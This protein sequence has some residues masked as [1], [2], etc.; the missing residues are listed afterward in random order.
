[1]ASFEDYVNEPYGLRAHAEFAAEHG[2]PMS[3]PEWGL[4]RNSDNPEYIQGMHD[5]IM[6]HDVVYQTITDYC[7]HGV[8][9]CGRNPRSA[10]RYRA[11]CGGGTAPPPTPK[12][13]AAPLP[14]D[15]DSTPPAPSPAPPAP[16]PAP[17]PAPEATPPAAP[18]PA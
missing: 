13:P 17:P 9:S 2:K 6:S 7:P 14:P 15:R 10:E 12:S 16:S 1:G 3:F 8:W 18:A 5:W 4:F 11:L